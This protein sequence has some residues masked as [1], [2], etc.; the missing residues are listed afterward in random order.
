MNRLIPQVEQ[1]LNELIAEHEQLLMLV[2]RKRL[3]LANAQPE[4]VQDCCERENALIQRIGEIEKRRQ[5]V[6]AQWTQQTHSA[7]TQPLTLREIAER[8]DEPVRG[9]LLMNQQRLQELMRNVQDENRVARDAT[10]GLLR[11]VQGMIRVISQAVSSAGVYGRKGVAAGPPA[12]ASSF[13]VTA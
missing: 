2:R 8:Q 12:M 4:L 13:A 7:A 1:C 5:T 3:A 11:H 10:E 6:V 9:R